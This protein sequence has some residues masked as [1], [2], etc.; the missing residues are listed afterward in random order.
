M[1]PIRLSINDKT[2][3]SERC[4][5][6]EEKLNKLKRTCRS[7]KNKEKQKS[8][9]RIRSLREAPSTL[10]TGCPDLRCFPHRGYKPEKAPLPHSLSHQGIG[11]SSHSSASLM[12]CHDSTLLTGLPVLTRWKAAA[13]PPLLFRFST[14]HHNGWNTAPCIWTKLLHPTICITENKTS[15][16]SKRVCASLACTDFI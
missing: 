7:S 13:L 10:W 9:G 15:S 2:F 5:K 1:E 11:F 14:T 6:I 4:M 8:S 16:Y 3:L 12:L